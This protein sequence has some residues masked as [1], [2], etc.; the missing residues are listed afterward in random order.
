MTAFRSSWHLVPGAALVALPWLNPRTSGPSAAVEPWI[1]G[2]AC[3]LALWLL[4]GAPRL[5]LY[6]PAWALVGWA[7]VAHGRVSPELVF[8]AAGL[9]LITVA[10]AAARDSRFARALQAGLLAAALVSAAIALVQYF[11]A[12]PLL[13]P[14]VNGAQLGEAHANLRQPNQFATLCWIGGAVLV[15][16]T[17]RIGFVP[18]GAA[19]LLLAAAGAASVSR[20]FVL[21]GIGLVVLAAAWPHPDRRR[22]LLLCA[23]AAAAYLGASWALP[24]LLDVFHGTLPERTFWGRLRADDACSSRLVLWS[25]VLHLLAHRPLLGWGWGELDY[26]HYMTLYPGPRFC[27]ILDNAHNLPLHLAVELGLPAAL[28]VCGAAL[29]WAWRRRPR[30]E[31]SPLRQ[32]AWAVLLLVLLHS[33]L[34]Y[35][36]WYAPF[37]SVFGIALGW[38]AAP[39]AAESPAR[40]HRPSLAAGAL[41]LAGTAYAAWDYTRVSQIYLKPDQR[42][43]RWREDTLDHVRQS[44]LFSGQGRFAALTLTSPTAA[45]A[46]WMFREAEASLHYSPEP[47]VIE[48][49]IESAAAVGEEDEAVLHLA[50]YRAAFPREA[51]TWGEALRQ[52]LPARP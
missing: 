43:A 24:M 8:L 14:W 31:R 38:L 15:F 42:A 23:I 3:V 22:R 44:W 34:E 25:N 47:R 52:P 1:V 18:A 11:G 19:L 51:R 29:F 50:R 46:P 45:N 40:L 48:R 26:A 32:L 20:T 36:L 49:M 21:E 10:A 37:Q 41:L 5:R 2:M 6:W 35:P 17:L 30:E 7:A 39:A 12:A 16:G 33:L 28:L 4:A 9:A 13:S 27:D